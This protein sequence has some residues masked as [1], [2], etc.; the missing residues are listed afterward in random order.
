MF[1]RDDKYMKAK[2]MWDDCDR[3]TRL[4][5]MLE[6]ARE[7]DPDAYQGARFNKLYM[8]EVQDYTQ[9]EISMFFTHVWS[10]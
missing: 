7:S 9:A 6:Y 4:A 8:D 10:W 5:R 2:G 3:I 1:A